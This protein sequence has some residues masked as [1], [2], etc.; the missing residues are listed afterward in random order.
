MSSNL[1]CELDELSKNQL[2]IADEVLASDTGKRKQ[3]T[4]TSDK[5]LAIFRNACLT[6][7]RTKDLQRRIH[8][9]LAE[10]ARLVAQKRARVDD[11]RLALDNL[12]YKRAHLLREISN[13]K[14]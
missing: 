6:I 5:M 9:K 1:Q 4:D 7:A 10:K 13:S 2:N 3:S 14:R 8:T 11:A 12:S